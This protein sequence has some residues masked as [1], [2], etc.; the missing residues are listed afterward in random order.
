MPHAVCIRL[1]L[2]LRLRF[3]VVLVI[4]LSSDVASS[5]IKLH[6]SWSSVVGGD[7]Q[8][9]AEGEALTLVTLVKNIFHPIAVFPFAWY[10]FFQEC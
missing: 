6:L 1:V 7:L 9:I 5:D 4:Y 2:L 3:V 10:T 8:N